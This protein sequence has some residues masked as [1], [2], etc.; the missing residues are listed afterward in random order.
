MLPLMEN[1]FIEPTIKEV[2][3]SPKQLYRLCKKL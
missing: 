1:G 3:N 2:P